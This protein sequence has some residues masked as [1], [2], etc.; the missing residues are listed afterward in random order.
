MRLPCIRFGNDSTPEA[1]WEKPFLPFVLLLAFVV[2]I[3]MSFIVLLVISVQQ[4]LAPIMPK[5][6]RKRWSNPLEVILDPNSDIDC[7]HCKNK[8]E[9]GPVDKVVRR[10]VNHYPIKEDIQFT[11]CSHCTKSFKRVSWHPGLGTEWSQWHEV[12]ESSAIE[13]VD[14]P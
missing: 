13:K 11:T 12:S 4:L 5:H 6:I 14:E 9:V 1:N 2:I 10:M 3:S 7:P 8:L